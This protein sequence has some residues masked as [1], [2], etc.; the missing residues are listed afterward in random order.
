MGRET[1]APSGKFC[2]AIPHG[3]TERGNKR[4]LLSE[5]YRRAERKAYGK[6]FGN[7]VYGDGKEEF[8]GL[9]KMTF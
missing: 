6:T 8:C 5:R 4:A 2:I 7:I 9:V 3:K 1:A